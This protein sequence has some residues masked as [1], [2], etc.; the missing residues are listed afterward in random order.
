MRCLSLL[1]LCIPI[2]AQPQHFDT[3]A[4][5]RGRK[6]FQSSCGFCHGEDATGNRAPDLLRSVSLSHDVNGEVVG[7][8]I[9]N[10]RPDKEMPAFGNL[11]QPQ[12]A[13]IVAF[14]HKAAYDALHSNGVPRDYP[15]V[16]LLTGN[17]SDGKIFFDAN[18][19][20]CH[21]AT[22]DLSNIAK[23]Y[24][25]IDLQQRMLYPGGDRRTVKVTTPDGKVV[26][27][28]LINEDEFDVALTGSDGSY[29]SWPRTSVK[30]EI[31]DPLAQHRALMEK[32]T[33][34]DMHNVFAYL[35]SL[36]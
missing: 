22:G 1:L 28:K 2:W 12:I 36:K 9:R 17:A 5:D 32:Y 26:E 27:G 10:G 11:T 34:R 31:H 16:K 24:R 33:D 3:S 25:P 7:P 18:C 19:T 29:H 35:E 20:S 23:K 6:T 13:D 4:V 30:V 14:L 8:I 15:L 21:S